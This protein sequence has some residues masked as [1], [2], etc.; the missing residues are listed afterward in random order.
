[1]TDLLDRVEKYLQAEEDAMTSYDEVNAG[2]KRRDLLVGT[3]RGDQAMAYKCYMASCKAE[4]AFTIE[5][6]RDEHAIRQ[7]EQVEELVFITLGGGEEFVSK[8][9]VRCLPF[10]KALKKIK[11]FEWTDECQAYFEALKSYLTTPPLLSKPLVGEE[12]FLYL[13][14]AESAIS[15]V[16]VREQSGKQLPIYYGSEVLQGA[17]LRYPNMEKLVF[18]LLIAA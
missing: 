18:A 12:L 9:I 17:E 16:L 11:D 13:A 5:D 15:A 1:M 8:S 10:F 7:V 2:Q 6:Q 14:I 3:V 4:E